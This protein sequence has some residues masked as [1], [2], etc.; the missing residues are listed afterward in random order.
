MIRKRLIFFAVAVV[1]ALS[2]SL[3]GCV[4]AG[5][6]FTKPQTPSS[7][8]SVVYFY[9]KNN[10]YTNTTSPG[11]L[12]NGEHVLTEMYSQGYW[13]YE[14]P[15]G[16]HSFE[17]KEFGIY[18]AGPI[19]LKN[20]MPGQIYYVEMEVSFGYIGFNR[21]S[22]STGLAEI[23]ECHEITS[24]PRA[25]AA[26]ST[27]NS[28]QKE[29]TKE[30]I[31]TELSENSKM[32]ESFPKSTLHVIPHPE[33]ARIR[34]MNIKPKFYQGIELKPGKYQI[35]V[36]AK[37]YLTEMKWIQIKK[38]EAIKLKINLLSQ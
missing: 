36:S 1:L 12:H 24:S 10:M 16:V 13:R 25:K 11:I 14:I 4:S 32:P 6:K 15:I 30:A 17:P 26:G 34:I 5:A 21:K 3:S 27:G 23:S 28:V 29:E 9:R 20:N 38:E 7:G 18:K 22:E 33:N 19:T 31:V 8:K 35:E 37:G 2:F